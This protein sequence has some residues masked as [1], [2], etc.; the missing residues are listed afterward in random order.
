MVRPPWTG[1][2]AP[3]R[4]DD[5]AALL[6]LGVDRRCRKGRSGRFD[7]IVLESIACTVRRKR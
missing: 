5:D 6:G 3:S 2:D 4:A 7:P 1:D